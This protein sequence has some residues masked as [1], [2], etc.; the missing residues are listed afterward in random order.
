MIEIDLSTMLLIILS[1]GSFSIASTVLSYL[2]DHIRSSNVI[3]PASLFVGTLSTTIS[4]VIR[5]DVPPIITAFSV[6]LV[7]SA[8]LLLFIEFVI[9]RRY[10]ER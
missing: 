10:I 4:F 3:V 2:P 1:F 9:G 6:S 7:M 8:M 5:E